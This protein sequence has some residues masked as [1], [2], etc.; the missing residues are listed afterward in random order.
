VR[1][2]LASEKADVTESFNEHWAVD[3]LPP[4]PAVAL[5][6]LNMMAGTD[7]SLLDLCDLIRS[8]PAF[9]TAVLR[10]ANSPLIGF[11]KQIT[12]V[13]QA[14][15][16]LGFRRLKSA[17]IT[18]G[19]RSYLEN[20]YT[21]LLQSC[22]RHCL[23]CAIVAERT[24]ESAF[25]DKN[26]AHTAGILHDIGRIAMATSM[27]RSYARV[28]EIEA[29]QPEDLLRTEGEICGIDHCQAGLA[30]V[31]AW[32]LPAAFI[33]ITSCHHNDEDASPGVVCLVRS[34]C[35][36]ADNLVSRLPT[37]TLPEATTLSS[38]NF[39]RQRAAGCLRTP[40]N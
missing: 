33:E 26:F 14:S 28:L 13:L 34:S 38:L 10:L 15:M 2:V 9:S 39:P 30:L 24:A 8:D 22:W 3:D 4:F 6:A 29:N 40:S 5:R 35:M 18:I 7:T 20:L 17:V 37:I 27:P 11:P 21:P 32:E 19:L 31:K 12:S 36:V 25:L 23:A 16:L 1:N